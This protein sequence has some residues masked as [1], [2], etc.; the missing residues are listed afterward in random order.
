MPSPTERNTRQRLAIREV[1]AA[2]GMPIPP[3][4]IHRQ[5]RANVEGLGL[6]T[7]YRTLK[8]LADAGIITAV[9]IP[10][11]PPHYELAGKHHHHHFHCRACGRVFEVEGCCGH[12]EE[13]A[14]R[15][16][17]IEGHEVLLFGRCADCVKL[18]ERVRTTT[19]KRT[20]R[21]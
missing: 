5:A 10:G 2:S 9:E 7:V 14:P 6:A 13:H 4:E 21:S 1:I 15:G 19:A 12:F 8:L 17:Q 3:R 18:P 11:Q 16:F 20:T